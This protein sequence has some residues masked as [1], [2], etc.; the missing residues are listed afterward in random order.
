MSHRTI[1]K[2]LTALTVVALA[3]IAP[4]SA[5]AADVTSTGTVTAG[6]LSLSTA[7]APTFSSTIDGTDK[8]P[9]FTLPLTVT[10]ARGS[11]AGWKTELSSTAFTSGAHSLAGDA[12]T[13]SGVT[14]ACVDGATCTNPTNA[15]TYPVTLTETAA[16]LYNAAADTGMGSFTVTPTVDVKIPANVYAGTYTST[17]TVAGTTGP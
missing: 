9:N 7:A 4:A 17:L 13:I 8:T 16:K 3:A 12:A 5:L 14:V 15:V 6:T 10:D 1:S 2:R 11:G